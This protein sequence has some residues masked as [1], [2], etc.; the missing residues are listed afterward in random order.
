[1]VEKIYS[2]LLVP[3][4]RMYRPAKVNALKLLYKLAATERV[5]NRYK[6][7]LFFSN[8]GGF[9]G[10]FAQTASIRELTLNSDTC[11]VLHYLIGRTFRKDCAGLLQYLS[12]LRMGHLRRRIAAVSLLL[13]LLEDEKSLP[14]KDIQSF[15]AFYESLIDLLI[16]SKRIDARTSL[17]LASNDQE[18]VCEVEDEN[19]L[20]LGRHDW[21]LRRR[22]SLYL[23]TQHR[24]QNALSANSSVSF[25]K[26]SFEA[27]ATLLLYS[28]ADEENEEERGALE[29]TLGELVVKALHCILWPGPAL[30]LAANPSNDQVN[31]A[32][33][34][35]YQVF[36]SISD[37]SANYNFI[38]PYFWILQR[39]LEEFLKSTNNCLRTAG[40]R[41]AADSPRC[42]M[43]VDETCNRGV[44]SEFEFRTEL[45]DHM[46]E[47]MLDRLR[48]WDVGTRSEECVALSLHFLLTWASRGVFRDNGAA[49]Q[50][51]VRLHDAICA[52]K[53]SVIME[54]V[55][56]VA[57][58]LYFLFSQSS[59][60]VSGIFDP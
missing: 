21:N 45:L 20:S 31:D 27:T 10:F 46:S 44:S 50:A 47:L 58:F 25:P 1:M 17:S 29:E 43:I 19:F 34:K 7:N 15:P 4:E 51:C 59:L 23:S 56:N 55:R 39:V 57:L 42:R 14:Q 52:F 9:R 60:L 2:V 28:P 3:N 37:S 22:S 41:F 49:A 11:Q 33:S 12:L 13:D 36:V 6:T 38:K 5:A 32:L 8:S 18:D 35:Y 54:R 26:L 40:Q 53:D 24:T 48:V 30:I 16:K